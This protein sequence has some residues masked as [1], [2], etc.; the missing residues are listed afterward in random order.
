M[1]TALGPFDKE[2][3]YL[4]P[5]AFEI[6]RLSIGFHTYCIG[7]DCEYELGMSLLHMET[8]TTEE[9]GI[10]ILLPT[11]RRGGGEKF[12]HYLA[13][14]DSR[15]SHTIPPTTNINHM[16][17]GGI[18]RYHWHYHIPSYHYYHLYSTFTRCK[19]ILIQ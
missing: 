13:Q 16:E 9:R 2:I 5:I 14:Y 8:S 7:F 6:Y 1:P 18:D 3:Q 19:S 15:V 4:K 10:A 17:R 12:P 11:S